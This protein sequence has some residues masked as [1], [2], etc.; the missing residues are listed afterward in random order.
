[1]VISVET[2][3]V[4]FSFSTSCCFL[5][6]ID[7]TISFMMK[8]RMCL[9]LCQNVCVCVMIKGAEHGGC[10]DLTHVACC[11]R[12]MIGIFDIAIDML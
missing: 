1:M 10:K 9:S 8:H 6:M 2:G 4:W 11:V 7:G 5:L 12:S 3:S